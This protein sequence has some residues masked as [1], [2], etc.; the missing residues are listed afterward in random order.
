LPERTRPPDSNTARCFITEGR[1][2]A[3]GAASSFTDAGPALSLSTM[4]RRVASASAWKQAVECWRL[5]F[6]A[7]QAAVGRR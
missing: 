5:R 3:N 2:I 1:A 4:S 6:D 7:H